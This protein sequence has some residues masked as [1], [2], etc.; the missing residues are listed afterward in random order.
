[1]DTDI[2]PIVIGS[3]AATIWTIAMVI[4]VITQ[5]NNKELNK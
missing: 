2:I 5:A 3:I 1:M 4:S